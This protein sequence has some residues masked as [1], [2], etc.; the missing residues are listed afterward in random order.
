LLF[1][2]GLEWALGPP[3]LRDHLDRPGRRVRRV[4]RVR[5]VHLDRHVRLA[6]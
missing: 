2:A 1:F 4:R 3:G 6:H 5:H